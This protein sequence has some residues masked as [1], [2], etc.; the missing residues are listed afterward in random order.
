MLQRSRFL[1]LF[2]FAGFLFAN[3]QQLSDKTVLTIADKPVT[4]GEFLRVYKKNLNL[5]ADAEQKKVE[6]YLNLYIDY[7]LK[8]EAAYAM[9]LD[10]TTAHKTEYRK[11]KHKLATTY[12]NVGEVT[13]ELMKEAFARQKEQILARHI[14][15]GVSPDA[16]PQDTLAAYNEAVKLRGEVMSGERDF[17]QAARQFSD[18]PSAPDMGGY[19]DWFSVFKMVYPFET[20]A[21]NTPVG[22]V[23]DV[24]RT[25]FGYHF[26][27]V[28][29]RR[30]VAPEVTVSHIMIAPKK[31]DPDFDPEARINELYSNLQQGASFEELAKQYSDDRNTAENGGQLRRFG[32]GQL[33]A[34]SFERQAFALANAGDYS[35]PFETDFGWHVVKLLERHPY[36]TFE[37]VQSRLRQQVQQARRLDYI[38]ELSKQ[39]LKDR[40]GVVS[41][42]HVIPFFTE[43]LTDSITT[44]TWK[45][46]DT[47][48]PKMKTELFTLGTTTFTY[49]DFARFI[50][51]RQRLSRKAANTYGAAKL[52]Y[53]EFELATIRDYFKDHLDEE[54]EGFANV[55]REYKEGLLIFDLME[56]TIWGKVRKDSVGLQDFYNT[57]ISQYQYKQRLTGLIATT[58]NESVAK[59]LRKE[60]K[61]GATLE[62]LKT[63]F[64]SDDET[65]VLFSEG[66]YE[67][68][69]R[70]LP[71]DYELANGVSK[72]HNNNGQFT[73]IRTDQLIAPTAIPL[74][75][76]RGKVM[77][78]YQQALEA[79]FMAELKSKFTVNIDQQV[80]SEIKAQL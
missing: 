23:S 29:D 14:L 43:F 35:K 61:K 62:D 73:I 71:K 34:E 50:E 3:A 63:M 8:V 37:Q 13:D 51:D 30:V 49:D 44:K 4:A 66:T 46:T 47:L 20:V 75:K 27:E 54:D 15:I 24:F 42:D 22:E 69:H 57:N 45:Y 25:Q 79:G 31:D 32:P 9:G 38:K 52:F 16:L 80:L 67:A 1:L 60:L 55:V 18:D 68:G 40:Y 7:K 19:I 12:M 5:V 65:Q 78:D 17:E 10:T 33:N 76:I 48:N 53:D 70:L 36:P 74:D 28:L 58:P 59:K 39:E 72:I 64:N 21:Y 6:N 2:F 41:P 26:L 11:Y 77:G 56:N